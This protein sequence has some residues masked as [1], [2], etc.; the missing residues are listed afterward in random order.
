MAV[1]THI[2]SEQVEDFLKNYNIGKLVNL[3]GITQGVENTNYFV[4]TDQGRFVLT[5][6]EK[7]VNE[8]D[9][10]YFLSFSEYLAEQGIA[11]PKALYNKDG[12]N[13][14]T[15]EG[16]KAVIITFLSGQSLMNPS[17]IAC[18]SAAKFFAKL[19]LAQQGFS[20]IRKNEMFLD[21][22]KD[23]FEK[24][25]DKTDII[26]SD[27]N[28]LIAQEIT[29]LENNLP[30]D[31]PVG[32]IHSDLFTDNVFFEG[33]EVSGVIDFYFSCTDILVYDLAICLNAWCF[34]GNGTFIEERAAVMLEAYDSVR[35]LS[36]EEKKALGI[37]LRAS[38]LRFLLT[39]SHD[40][41]FHDKNA[42]VKAKDP[43]EY[44]NILKFHQKHN[45][46]TIPSAAAS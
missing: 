13:I 37:L 30:Q 39:R 31:L 24:I 45:I 12:K 7:R 18:C 16:K 1:Y 23:L 21:A 9:L 46:L 28:A 32:N 4:D 36:D 22:W 15:I 10:P 27:L 35:P 44:Y 20:G 33:D 5:L 38:A 26:G 6:F 40:W 43:K 2:T 41:I 17:L 14:S 42:Q 25:K 8:D 34:D 11:C 19:H 29:Y 3:Q